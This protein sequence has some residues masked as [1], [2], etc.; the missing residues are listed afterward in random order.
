MLSREIVRILTPLSPLSW[1]SESFRQDIG[2]FH[3]PRMKHLSNPFSRFQLGKF[4]WKMW[5]ISIKRWKLEACLSR[6]R[7]TLIDL[8]LTQTDK[9][10]MNY[11]FRAA[12][13]LAEVFTSSESH[14]EILIDWSLCHSCEKAN[15]STP[16]HLE[17][18]SWTFCGY[19]HDTN[20]WR[21]PKE[22]KDVSV[23]CYESANNENK[24]FRRH[25]DSTE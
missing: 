1:V 5:P 16:G 19:G 10:V 25:G 11:L 14:C 3:A 20:V 7:Q 17:S 22:T 18:S 4:L 13:G 2:Q 8:M 23:E 6:S 12:N 9:K 15:H 24:Y 21:S